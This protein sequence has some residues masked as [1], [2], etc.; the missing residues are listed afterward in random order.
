MK[1]ILLVA[2]VAVLLAG[3]GLFAEAMT[4]GVIGQALEGYWNDVNL[5]AQ[6]AGKQLGIN[7]D[8]YCPTLP[9][10]ENQ[11]STLQSFIGEKF[12]GIAISC[13]DPGG[14]VPYLENAM[15]E[16]IPV[17]TIDTDAASTNARI[18]FIG[19]A[20][21]DAGYLG[22]QEMV[23]LLHGK[24]NVVIETGS[25]SAINSLQRI[26]GFK[27]ALKG[28]DIKV[29]TVLNENGDP[30]TALSE[31]QSAI[32]SYG[33]QLNGFYGVYYE[34]GPALA[35]AVK[36]AGLKPGQ[37]KIVCFDMGPDTLEGVKSGYI[38]AVTVQNPYLMGYLSVYSL[39]DM[40]K[41]GSLGP[42]YFKILIN[43]ADNINTGVMLVTPENLN[44]YISHM[45]A[46]GLPA[47][48]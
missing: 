2:V 6:T 29:L 24:G 31:A 14:V 9:S 22:G 47:Y 10:A 8:F 32:A 33:K 25:L 1:K 30:S 40:A 39:Y 17:V 37:I 26:E 35:R 44:E 12:A 43:G 5:G 41:M 38:N 45:K 4:I 42:T 19:T 16:G 11:I 28:T 20:N 23:K 18:V 3:L 34:D 13:T 27:A 46:L 21:Y 15:K 36:T 7:V 48:Y